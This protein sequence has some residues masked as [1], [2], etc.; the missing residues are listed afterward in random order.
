M[1]YDITVN[2]VKENDHN[3]KAFATVT[4]GNAFII[5]GIK[6][7]DSTNGLF[8]AMPNYKRKQPAAN[9]D[10]YRDICF[11]CTSDFTKELKN[12]IIDV[13]EGKNTPEIT[14]VNVTKIENNETLKGLATVKL[15][16]E[17]IISGIK[18]NIGKNGLFVSMPGY[19]TSDGYKEICNP[20]TAD[21]R[22][23]LINAVMEKFN[24]IDKEEIKED[25]KNLSEQSSS[26]TGIKSR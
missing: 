19:K 18:I 7:I 4:I 17:F 20:V 6:I 22:E 5:R 3:I 8:V 16:D 10:E 13:Y 21:F 12:A 25:N 15:D 2:N 24:T 26:K 1:K 9:G 14:S 23:K 11:P